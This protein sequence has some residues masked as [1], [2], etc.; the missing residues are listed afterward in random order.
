MKYTAIAAALLCA[1]VAA[2]AFIAPPW[3]HVRGNSVSAECLIQRMEQ[4]ANCGCVQ[5]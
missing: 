1:A 4:E 2:P 3:P 5:H